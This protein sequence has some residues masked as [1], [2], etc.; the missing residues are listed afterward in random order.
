MRHTFALLGGMLLLQSCGITVDD[1]PPEV[2]DFRING[3]SASFTAQ[4]PSELLVTGFFTDDIDLHSYRLDFEPLFSL[5]TQYEVPAAYSRDTTILLG[6]ERN[7][8][9][10]KLPLR[11]LQAGGGNYRVTLSIRDLAGNTTQGPTLQ[12]TFVNPYPIVRM[13]SFTTDS[14]SVKVGTPLPLSG[15]V[16]DPNADATSISAMV[17]RKKFAP[18]PGGQVQVSFDTLAELPAQ[19]FS[20]TASRPF[21]FNYTPTQ[22]QVLEVRLDAR[23]DS[24]RQT[25]AT[26]RI[27]VT[28]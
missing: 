3:E 18:L 13:Q 12:A 28:P 23:D 16:L 1:T 15:T 19:T 11:Q 25:T 14:L 22:A 26:L 8:V 21:S 2:S 4:V 24:Q 5:P 10:R 27:G 17:L 9:Y 20:P 6:G 7:Q